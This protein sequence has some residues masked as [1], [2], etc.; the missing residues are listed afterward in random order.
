MEN[1]S[2]NDVKINVKDAF[3]KALIDK[4]LLNDKR[5]IPDEKIEQAFAIIDSHTRFLDHLSIINNFNLAIQV[6]SSLVLQNNEWCG[7]EEYC[8]KLIDDYFNVFI[9]SYDLF[10]KNEIHIHIKD[11]IVYSCM[12]YFAVYKK[13]K[14]LLS[15]YNARVNNAVQEIIKFAN[16]PVLDNVKKKE[17]NKH[18]EVNK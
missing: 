11:Y 6:I 16:K 10:A 2:N 5:K 3:K 1:N 15:Q 7:S 4:H 9:G 13:D 14:E 12:V 8:I 17:T 18:E